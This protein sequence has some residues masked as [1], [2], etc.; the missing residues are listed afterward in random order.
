MFH[1]A[2]RPENNMYRYDL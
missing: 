2:L 1:I